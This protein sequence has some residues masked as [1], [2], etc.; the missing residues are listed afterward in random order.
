[1]GSSS[2][3]HGFVAAIGGLLLFPFV[4]ALLP[5]PKTLSALTVEMIAL[6]VLLI[7]VGGPFS[8]V[9]LWPMITEPDQRPKAS[10]FVAE[11]GTLP[12]TKRSSAVANVIG[13]VVLGG[14][15]VPE[16]SF[17]PAPP[18]SYLH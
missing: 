9:Y 3:G 12:W 14:L 10:A 18:S 4:V 16:P 1:M 17:S 13:T 2:P 6:I 8:L 5:L 15:L 7:L 11:G